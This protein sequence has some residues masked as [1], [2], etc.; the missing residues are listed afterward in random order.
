MNTLDDIN[1]LLN[2][3]YYNIFFYLVE[4]SILD[5]KNG[6]IYSNAKEIILFKRFN[7]NG[8]VQNTFIPKLNKAL[9]NKSIIISKEHFF[10]YV[11]YY[12]GKHFQIHNLPSDKKDYIYYVIIPRDIFNANIIKKYWKKYRWNYLKNLAAWKYHPSKLNFEI[13]L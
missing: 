10:E 11:S 8:W 3:Y 12:T 5:I 7:N 2:K 9:H 13:E 1:I 6:K 4:N